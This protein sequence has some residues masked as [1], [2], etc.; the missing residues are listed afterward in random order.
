MYLVLD[1]LGG[2]SQLRVRDVGW[3]LSLGLLSSIDM[4]DGQTIGRKSLVLV[5][6]ANVF[7]SEF[8]RGENSLQMSPCCL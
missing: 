4:E 8:F 6:V 5:P 1:M 2:E 7:D 3:M